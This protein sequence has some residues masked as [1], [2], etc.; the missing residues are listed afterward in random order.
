MSAPRTDRQAILL[1]LTTLQEARYRLTRVFDG[2]ESIEVHD[3][4]KAALDAITAVDEAALHVWRPGTGSNPPRRGWV[5]FVL[6]NAPWEV[7]CNH[8][9]NLSHALDPLM[10]T[11]EEGE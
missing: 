11:W 8:T 2:E 1:T 10:E 3:S 4:A 7:I 6:G 9:A 5:H